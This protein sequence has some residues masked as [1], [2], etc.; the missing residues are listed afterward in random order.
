MSYCWLRVGDFLGLPLNP[1][2]IYA[3][4]Y[5]AMCL[6]LI[7]MRLLHADIVVHGCMTCPCTTIAIS[8]CDNTCS[9]LI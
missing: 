3:D 1:F 2:N 5:I 4:H 9:H 6:Q 8:A 7:A